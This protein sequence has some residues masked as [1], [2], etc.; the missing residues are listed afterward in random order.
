[1]NVWEDGEDKVVKF[2]KAK[3]DG[4]SYPVAYTGKGSA[5]EKDWLKAAGV[6]G[7]PHAFVVKDGKLLFGTHPTQLTEARIEALLAGDEG[8]RKVVAELTA[9]AAAR[10]K[11]SALAAAF[12]AAAAKNDTTT[13]AAKLAE[14]EQ[15]EEKAPNLSSMKLDLM[16]AQKD[17]PAAIKQVGELDGPSRQVT[18]MLLSYKVSS[19]PDDAYPLDFSKALAKAF[20]VML[21]NPNGRSSPTDHVVRATLAWKAGDKGQALTSAKRAAALAAALPQGGAAALPAAPF[22]RFATAVEAGSP[23]SLSDFQGW[24]KEERAKAAPPAK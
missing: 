22:E 12:R 1:M 2:V 10:G 16:V 20:G 19:Q 18:L 17:W 5:F 6:T 7:I 14:I 4:M 15:L 21:D 3:G 23:P 9:S 8:V 24:L 13:M 11:A